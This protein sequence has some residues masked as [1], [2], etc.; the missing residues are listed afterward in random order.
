MAAV[1]TR[2]GDGA[3]F[4]VVVIGLLALAVATPVGLIAYQ[5][6]LDGPFFDSSSKVGLD[7]FRYVLGDSDFWRA[8]RTTALF[9]FG[10]VAVAV[11]LGAALAFLLTRTD[12]PGKGLL[13]ALVLVPMFLS[14]IVLAFGYT[15]AVGPS[16]FISLWVRELI[17]FVPW[18]L[19][20]LWGIIVVG[21]LSHVPNVY[22]YVSSAMRSLPS[23]LEEAARTSGASMW[24]VFLDVTLPMVL[25]A[26]IF[27]A[28]L[29]LLLGFETFGIP[30]VL[31]DPNG[32]LVLTTYIYKVSTVFGTPTYHVMAVVAVILVLIT[33]PLVFFQRRLLRHSRRF[34][35]VGGKGARTNVLKLGRTGTVV[36]ASAVGAWLAVSVLLP[37]GGVVLRAFVDAWGEGQLVSRGRWTSLAGKPV[38]SAVHM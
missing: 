15:V 36:A 8:L 38:D 21:G 33:L 3:I 37:V 26:L 20:S 23:D 25:P 13:E 16:G 17:G 12:M 32:I 2:P 29:N 30:L 9:A 4:R 11:P 34:A 6:F 31:G 18:N 1:P 7:A 35:A 14:S 5:S 28:A 22:L 19:Y 24:R 27:A 10:Q